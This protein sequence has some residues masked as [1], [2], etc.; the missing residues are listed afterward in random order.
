MASDVDEGVSLWCMPPEFLEFCTAEAKG[1]LSDADAYLA[2]RTR[3]VGLPY[4]KTDTGGV[5]HGNNQKRLNVVLIF[6]CG[7]T[8]FRLFLDT[9]SFGIGGIPFNRAPILYPEENPALTEP[10]RRVGYEFQL[11][12]LAPVMMQV[13]RE[14]EGYELPLHTDRPDWECA[15]SIT[16]GD[17][18]AEWLFRLPGGDTTV[19]VSPDQCWAVSGVG[20]R[21][22]A[23]NTPH[24]HAVLSAPRLAVVVRFKKVPTETPWNFADWWS[25]HGSDVPLT[26]KTIKFL[27]E[28][29]K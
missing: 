26:E 23:Y 28:T 8:L 15:V 9:C 10:A 17:G 11:I 29:N 27:N 14:D 12:G 24:S 3:G 20:H 22:M 13:L 19:N 16:L 25:Q 4:V 1:S 7:P 21:V 5:T 2:R 18:A 6:P